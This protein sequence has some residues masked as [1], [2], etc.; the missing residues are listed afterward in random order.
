MPQP[1]TTTIDVASVDEAIGSVEADGGEI[2]VPKSAVPG[3]GW[4]SDFKHTEGNISG[5]MEAGESAQ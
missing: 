1:V 4:L 2:L 5:M 3:V